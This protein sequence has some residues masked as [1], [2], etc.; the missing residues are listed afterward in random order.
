MYKLN[1]FH[2]PEKNREG[3]MPV[4][5]IALKKWKSNFRLEYSVRKNRTTFSSVPLLPEIFRWIDLK[6]HVPFTFQP[7][8][9]ET[10]CTGKQPIIKHDSGMKFT[11]PE[12]CLRFAQAVNRPKVSPM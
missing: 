5:K 3:L 4:S 7:D 8:F 11:N 12:F 2:L 10:F 6:S 9:P 1:L